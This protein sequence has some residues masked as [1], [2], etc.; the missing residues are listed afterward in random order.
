M[1]LHKNITRVDRAKLQHIQSIPSTHTLGVIPADSSISSFFTIV[2][3]QGVLSDAMLLI[4]GRRRLCFDLEG[5]DCDFSFWSMRYFSKLD[6][7]E[8]LASEKHGKHG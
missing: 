4:L 3:L 8:V 6:T 1:S 5:R 2:L 7:C